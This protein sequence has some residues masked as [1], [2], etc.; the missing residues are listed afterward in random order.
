MNNSTSRLIWLLGLALACRLAAMAL[1]PLMDTTEPR[2]AEIARIMAETG[3]WITPYFDY[4]IPFW[5][6]P[7]LS[8]WSQALSFKL[9]G[10]GEFPARLPSLLATLGI[11]WLVFSATRA[12]AGRQTAWLAVTIYGTSALGFVAAGA[13]L[14][15]PFLTFGTTL[16]LVAALRVGLSGGPSSLWGYLLFAG[17]G[18]GLLA[19][20]PLAPV[21]AL[22]PL[23]TWLYLEPSARIRH[24]PWVGG[25]LLALAISLPWY[26]A[27][28]LKTPGFLEYFIIGEHFL[29]FVD[30]G[31]N[32]DL[33]GSA[34]QAALGTIWWYA[35][36]ATFPWGLA[37]AALFV[38][39]VRRR[40]WHFPRPEGWHGLLLAGCLWPLVFFTFAG[41][42]LWTYVQPALPPFAMLLAMALQK[43]DS[44]W[45]HRAVVACAGLMPVVILAFTLVVHYRPG[46][47]KTEKQLVEFTRESGGA[48]AELLYLGDRPFS[49]RFYSAGSAKSVDRGE[50]DK[51]LGDRLA[52]NFYLAVPKERIDSIPA[53]PAGHLQEL[54]TN[55]R[56]ALFQASR[57]PG[58]DAL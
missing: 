41:N 58:A 56:Y 55:R 36:Q 17:L 57:K 32:G 48:Q 15:D 42:I 30:S 37:A 34:H 24:I 16:T 45:S 47:A 31:W 52:R 4:G 12:L 54:F 22:V 6:K 20:G 29:R 50:L 11:L 28:E 7:P 38:A 33:Y 10:V 51:L 18:I 27:A 46:S 44:R 1:L 43:S 3:D 5:G 19:K 2:Y 49:A 14:T 25:T 26:I 35:V 13:V 23:G 53:P 21:L 39:A 9:L 40:G 8:F